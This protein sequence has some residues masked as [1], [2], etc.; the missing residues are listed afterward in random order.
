M[1][2]F[3]A[4]DNQ[5]SCKDCC[6]KSFWDE[7]VFGCSKVHICNVSIFRIDLSW[8]SV[9]P[10]S[11]K[12]T[13]VIVFEAVPKMVADE[14]KEVT[15]P[16]TSEVFFNMKWLLY[17]RDVRKKRTHA[18]CVKSSVGVNRC[19]AYIYLHRRYHLLRKECVQA[20]FTM[21][22][23]QSL[24]PQRLQ[25]VIMEVCSCKHTH[26]CTR[27]ASVLRKCSCHSSMMR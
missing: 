23:L 18:M 12:R 9:R 24:L 6:C 4:D 17:Y 15:E 8:W 21:Q 19:P 7:H 13:G 5:N 26:T 20:L 22:M 25:P 14:R 1:R 3:Y 16:I 11:S 10:V 2:S 27:I